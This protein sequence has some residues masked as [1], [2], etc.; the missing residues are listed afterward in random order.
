MP[1]LSAKRFSDTVLGDRF[2]RT[3]LITARHLDDGARLI[4]DL[5]VA[6]FV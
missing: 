1:Q 6:P 2:S 5:E 4:G 3:V